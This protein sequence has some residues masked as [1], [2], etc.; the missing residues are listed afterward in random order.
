MALGE[1]EGGKWSIRLKERGWPVGAGC[2]RWW[3]NHVPCNHAQLGWKCWLGS[4]AKQNCPSR[5]VAAENGP[6]SPSPSGHYLGVQASQSECLR[7]S[8]QSQQLLSP[9][10]VLPMHLAQEFSCGKAIHILHWA[11][12][13]EQIPKE[14][15]YWL[16]KNQFKSKSNRLCSS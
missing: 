4:F 7:L 5:L 15:I 11:R 2:P 16:W 14:E 8:S 12:K 1:K 3:L 9:M 13:G 10:S 6:T